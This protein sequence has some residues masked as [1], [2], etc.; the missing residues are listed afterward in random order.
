MNHCPVYQNIGGH[1][2]GWVYPGTDRLDP[3]ADVRRARERARP[4]AGVD[5]LQPV[6]RRVPGEDPAAGPA[7]QAA[8]AGVRASDL[9]PWTERAGVA[10]WAWFARRPALYA[11]RA[12]IGVR[13][14]RALG[15]RDGMIR[16]LPFGGGW[17]DGTRH[18]GAG[19]PHVP[20]AVRAAQGA[21]A[22]KRRTMNAPHTAASPC[23]RCRAA[24]SRSAPR[25]PSSCSPKSTRS[26]RAGQGHRLVLHRPARLPDAAATCRMRRS[27][28]SAAASTATRRPRAS[29]SCAPRPRKDL[30]ARRGLDIAP[31][32][33]VVG[34]GAKPFIAYTIA[35]VTDYGAGDEVI[36]PVPGFPIYESQILANGAVPVP[37]YL[38]ESR[39][40][41][42]DPAELEAKI[43]PEDAPPDPQHAAESDRRHPRPRGP[44]RDRGDPA[45][46]SAGLGVRRRDLFAPRRTTARSTRSRRAPAC[47]SARS[48]ATA[49]RRP[50]R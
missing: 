27:R 30:G 15:G 44:R 21:R 17:T 12:R 34:A 3:D 8:R 36:Y 47:S 26:S 46:A 14:L 40:F 31:D 7:A 42:F 49:R 50:G 9:R 6:R 11:S 48:S 28:R 35:S 45:R 29:T 32:D 25:T 43:T 20:R 37:I 19:G 13:M 18:A 4:A 39:N 1:S 5:V 41:A 33:V 10:A 16:K 22:R 23:R 2:Y 38:R 24:P